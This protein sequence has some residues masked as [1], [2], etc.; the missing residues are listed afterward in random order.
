M[1]DAP[2][3]SSAS[4]GHALDALRPCTESSAGVVPLLAAFVPA[5]ILSA[6]AMG[7]SYTTLGVNLGFF[8]ASVFV[9]ALVTPPLTSGEQTPATRAAAGIGIVLGIGLLLLYAALHESITL[10][11]A[12]SCAA[13][14]GACV[15]CL[16]GVTLTLVRLARLPP[17]VAAWIAIWLF[18]A[19]LSW[20][21][22]LSPWIAGRETLV[23]WLSAAHPLLSVNAQLKHM[24]LWDEQ[25]YAYKMTALVRDVS[26]APPT[27]V[28]WAVVVH[29]LVGS[30]SLAVGAG[31]YRLRNQA[32]QR[33]GQLGTDGIVR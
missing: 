20:P 4:D 25:R 17:P 9:A 12:L 8:F 2:A 14:V 30:V 23:S 28:T 10:V 11:D 26:Y 18:L 27:G 31:F 13:V 24:G 7:V 32:G 33:W 15:L 6:S 19:W 29:S 21:V 16:T 22:W 5:L 3:L 1:S